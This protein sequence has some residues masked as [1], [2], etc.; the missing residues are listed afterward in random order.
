M[1]LHEIATRLSHVKWRGDTFMARCPA[2]KDRTPSLSGKSGDGGRTL[3][4]CHAGCRVEDIV[5]RV[6]LTVRDLFVDAT[7][8]SMTT[9]EIVETYPYT[10]EDGTLLYEVVRYVPKAFRQRRPDGRN[11]WIWKLDD[12]IFPLLF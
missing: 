1:D 10:A 2:H 8:P 11:G 9:P 7:T 5:A 4:K 6:G 3:L 12:P